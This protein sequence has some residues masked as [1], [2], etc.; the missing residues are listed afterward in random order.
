[1]A[2]DS[3]VDASEMLVVLDGWRVWFPSRVL[4]HLLLLIV[5]SLKPIR[6]ERIYCM[7]PTIR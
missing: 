6:L 1:V 3:F 7:V 4:I 2:T 5:V